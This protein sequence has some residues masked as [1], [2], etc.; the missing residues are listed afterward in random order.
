MTYLAKLIED[1]AVDTLLILGDITEEKN[2]HSDVLV[3]DVVELLYNFGCLCKVLILRGNHDYVDA[4]CPF[5]HF[6]RRISNVR[7]INKPTP[8]LQFGPDNNGLFLP[9]T[10]NYERD[11]KD[12]DFAGGENW[13]FAHNTFAQTKTDHGHRLKGIP[14]SVFPKGVKVLSGDVHTPQTIGPV[15][16]IGAPYLVDWGDDYEPR[17]LLLKG[18]KLSSLP[19]VGPQK[20]L[21]EVSSFAE[22]AKAAVNEGDVVKVRFHLEAWK[23][24]NWSEMKV[25]IRKALLKLGVEAHT[26]Q[27]VIEAGE[28]VPSNKQRESHRVRSDEDIVRDFGKAAKAEEPVIKTGLELTRQV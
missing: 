17:V 16:Y 4:D 7:W 22:L 9:H 18:K 27:P 21:V 15:T 6:V 2:F 20:R 25:D 24:E 23:K 3:N 13:I 1:H 26:I 14:T 11:W 28:K 8:R 12:V 5:F 19:M 10:L